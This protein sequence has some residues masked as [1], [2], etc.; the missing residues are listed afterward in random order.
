MYHIRH[1][2]FFVHIYLHIY[3]MFDSQMLQRHFSLPIV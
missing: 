1:H 3:V 2:S